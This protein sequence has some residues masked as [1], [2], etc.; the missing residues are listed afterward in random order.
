MTNRNSLPGIALHGANRSRGIRCV[1][2]SHTVLRHPSC[3]ILIHALLLCGLQGLAA[4][5]VAAQTTLGSSSFTATEFYG[6]RGCKTATNCGLSFTYSGTSYSITEVHLSPEAILRVSFSPGPSAALEAAAVMNFGGTALALSDAVFWGQNTLLWASTG[7]DWAGGPSVS[8]SVETRPELATP[9]VS[10][11]ASPNP[12][13][14]GSTVTVTATLSATLSASVTIPLTLTD[15]SAEPA[16]RGT[17]DSISVVSNATTG[18]GTIATYQDSDTDD[19]RFTVALDVGNLPSSVAAGTPSSVQVRIWDDDAVFPTTD[20]PD[21]TVAGSGV[22]KLPSGRPPQLALWTDRPGYRLGETVRLYRTVA[23]P[24]D[25]GHYRTFVYLMRTGGGE[26]RY[27]APLSA[28]GEL[29]TEVVD[30]RGRPAST[31]PA[32][33]VFAA[34]RELSWEGETP[35]PGLWQFVME[36]QPATEG[37]PDDGLFELWPTRRAYAKFTVAERSQLLHRPGF[38]REVTADMTLRSDTLYRMGHRLFVHDGATLTIE[39]GTVVLAWGPDTA[40]IVEPGGRIV[41]EGTRE[42]PVVLTCSSPVGQREPGCWGGLRLLGRAPVTRQQGVAPGVLPADR[43]VYGGTDADGLSGVLRYVRVEFAGA[44]GDPE[45]PGPA[46]GLYGTGSATLLDHVQARHSL[47]DGFAFSGGSAR[48][49]HCV[50]S[51]SGAA[52]LAWQRGW[53]GAASHLY[54]HH[55]EG[56]TDG[57]DGRGDE[58]GYDREPRSHPTVEFLIISLKQRENLSN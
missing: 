42:A 7:L 29:H 38:D 39:A 25:S 23:P 35:A 49:D 8:M 18:T 5:P 52:G 26:R 22:A 6:G 13:A 54:V 15:D 31:A 27:L 3:L 14:E 2:L 24:D 4:T 44:T 43:S 19:E 33:S 51:A 53:R 46:I 55:G 32:R 57:I 47:G 30:H 48:C 16:D 20:S 1:H 10:L 34:S 58:D 12:V 21:D 56:G 28:T 17:L 9:T 41:A 50:A 11:S 40:I 37:Q 45:A 36:L